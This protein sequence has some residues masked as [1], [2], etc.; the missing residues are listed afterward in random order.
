MIKKFDPPLMGKLDWGTWGHKKILPLLEDN[1]ITVTIQK[2]GRWSEWLTTEDT[3]CTNNSIIFLNLDNSILHI[4]GNAY[5]I[6]AIPVIECTFE[7]YYI[8]LSHDLPKQ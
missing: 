7:N 6:I 1:N 8:H 5:G 3:S 2:G 4:S